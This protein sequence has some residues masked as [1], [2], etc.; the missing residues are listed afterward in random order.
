MVASNNKLVVMFGFCIGWPE[1]FSLLFI[2]GGVRGI[3]DLLIISCLIL[4]KRFLKYH[5]FR[6]FNAELLSI[7]FFATIGLTASLSG[8]I[9]LTLNVS[10]QV[11]V[12]LRFLVF[13]TAYSLAVWHLLR[14]AASFK[15]FIAQIRKGFS[16]GCLVLLLFVWALWL[17]EP[18]YMYG[19]PILNN[20][21]IANSGFSM[22]RNYFGFYLGWCVVLYLCINSVLASRFVDRIIIFALAISVLFTLS[23][24]TWM[25]VTLS[26]LI[27]L[28]NNKRLTPVLTCL[29]FL[30]P[31]VLLNSAS[32]LKWFSNIK[33]GHR[34]DYV[35]EA[36]EIISSRVIIGVGDG[37]YV[38]HSGTTS[39]GVTKDPHNMWLWLWAEV[40]IITPFLFLLALLT[41][42]FYS[43]VERNFRNLIFIPIFYLFIRSF[44]TGLPFSSGLLILW[45]TFSF[46]LVKKLKRGR[47]DLAAGI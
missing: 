13:G 21:E 35:V 28:T 10:S 19:L 1:Q 39:L 14:G 36:I 22:N 5:T 24:G 8:F 27:V 4:I 30:G 45:I 41:I 6:F 31:L 46:A 43:L 25:A 16:Y 32:I 34:I 15:E 17:L 40:G 2:F 20:P 44:E 47:L 33:P 29:T 12:I 7:A 18:R 26:S 9:N 42:T 11:D 23:R 38:L 37:N 3:P